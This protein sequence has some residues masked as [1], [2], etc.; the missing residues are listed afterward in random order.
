MHV[1]HPVRLKNTPIIEAIVEL[2]FYSAFPSS[3]I[4]GIIYSV[5]K[6][7]YSEMFPLG[8]ADVPESVRIQ[9][10][11]M[12]YLPLYR[13]VGDKQVEVRVGP[14]VLSIIYHKHQNGKYPGWADYIFKELQYVL[15]KVKPLGLVNQVERVG[16]RTWDF[17]END[18]IFDHLE[19]SL[20]MEQ[21]SI[22]NSPLALDWIVV[23]NDFNNK[24][25]INN[26]INFATEE[27]VLEG[28][29]IDIDT[30]IE[31]IP[32]NFLESADIIIQEAHKLNKKLFFDILK[33]EYITKYEP[34][35]E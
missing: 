26:K 16:V 19:L 11:E 35:Y 4:P 6:D 17:F 24:I 32:E 12:M 31:E 2:R 9:A 18:N 27:K 28:S 30:Y 10:P 3:A 34:E 33:K 7:V 8:T 5:L 13:L 15:D 1:P 23:E 20:M 29:I 22:H 25:T 21:K 14:K